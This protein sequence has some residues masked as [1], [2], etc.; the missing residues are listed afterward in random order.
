MSME[1]NTDGVRKTFPVSQSSVI[2]LISGLLEGEREW[3][4]GR[5]GKGGIL[6][7]EAAGTRS[8]S[9]TPVRLSKGERAEFLPVEARG[10]G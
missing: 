9:K 7:A 6:P 4:A 8:M 3:G 1:F 2:P 10:D 5:M